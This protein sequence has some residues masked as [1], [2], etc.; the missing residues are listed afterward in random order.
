MVTKSAENTTDKD[1]LDMP[2]VSVED[3]HEDSDDGDEAV[4][5]TEGSYTSYSL[6]P[7]RSNSQSIMLIVVLYLNPS[8]HQ[9]QASRK[10]RRKRRSPKRKQKLEKSSNLILLV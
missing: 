9:L 2:K 8:V 6:N 10:R 1:I 3:Q 7:N 5:E 4:Q